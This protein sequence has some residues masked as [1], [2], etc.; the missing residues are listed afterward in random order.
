M[1]R[2]KFDKM[3]DFLKANGAA[4]SKGSRE[5]YLI[6]ESRGEAIKD[7]L[8]QLLSAPSRESVKNKL[9]DFKT[10]VVTQSQTEDRRKE[11]T[12]QKE[13]QAQRG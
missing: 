4:Y 11:P 12:K 2:G 6:P 5:W 10:K 8:K 13:A 9:N 7:Y 1:K 3:I